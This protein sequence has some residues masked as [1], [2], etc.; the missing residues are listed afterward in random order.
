MFASDSNSVYLTM[1]PKC[2][3][4]LHHELPGN[5]ELLYWAR[6]SAF[7]DCDYLYLPL[8]LYSNSVWTG[9]AQNHCQTKCFL[10]RCL[11]TSSIVMSLTFVNCMGTCCCICSTLWHGGGVEGWRGGSPTMTGLPSSGL[12]FYLVEIVG[13]F[14]LLCSTWWLIKMQFQFTDGTSDL[15]CNWQIRLQYFIYL[16]SIAMII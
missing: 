14:G 8:K 3:A 9:Q 2:P 15:Y 11:H 4:P 1:K 16:Y 10:H 5:C 13:K 7:L 6:T 12:L